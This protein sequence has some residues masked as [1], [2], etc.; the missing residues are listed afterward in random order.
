MCMQIWKAIV[1]TKVS[2]SSCLLYAFYRAVSV[3]RTLRNT[4]R[5]AFARIHVLRTRVLCD[6]RI[7][8]CRLVECIYNKQLPQETFC[9]CLY[10]TC[11]KKILRAHCARAHY[12]TNLENVNK[13]FKNWFVM[14]NYIGLYAFFGTCNHDSVRLQIFIFL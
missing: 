8:L 1:M 7:T 14:D 4:P 10:F 3:T 9:F 6:V 2:C 12:F 5:Y 13:I 11:T